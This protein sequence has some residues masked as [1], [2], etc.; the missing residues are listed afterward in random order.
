ME[1][2][3]GL[4]YSLLIDAALTIGSDCDSPLRLTNLT[5][6]FLDKNWASEIDFVVCTSVSYPVSGPLRKRSA[7][8]DW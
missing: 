1:L 7:L 4:P 3:S 6:D 5:L 8:R 2:R